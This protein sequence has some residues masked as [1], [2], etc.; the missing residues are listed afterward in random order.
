MK[1]YLNMRVTALALAIIMAV[2]VSAISVSAASPA[3]GYNPYPDELLWWTDS[4]FT[5][6]F[7]DGTG[8]EGSAYGYDTIQE[9][10]YDSEADEIIYVL[11]PQ[12]Y[13]DTERPDWENP[14]GAIGV[15]TITSIQV[16]ADDGTTWVTVTDETVPESYVKYNGDN[17]PYLF[18]T[19]NAL[20]VDLDTKIPTSIT[21]NNA[22]L[23]IPE[24][25]F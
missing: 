18:C 23:E 14:D 12:Y 1:K 15:F 19:V 8:V 24:G 3:V 7:S 11:H 25:V 21:L 17:E 13:H 20:Y 6:P 2:S 10:V 5:T 22:Y 9:I 16:S 4:T